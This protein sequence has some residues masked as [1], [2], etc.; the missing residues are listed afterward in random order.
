[1]LPEWPNLII[2]A[3]SLITFLESED[4][5][6]TPDILTSNTLRGCVLNAPTVLEQLSTRLPAKEAFVESDTK[7][8]C[9]ND[10]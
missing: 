3:A 5:E 1:M 9:T 2:I 4:D 6:A 7:C 8:A 10:R